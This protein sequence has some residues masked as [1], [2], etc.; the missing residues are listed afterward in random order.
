MAALGDLC[1]V[2]VKGQRHVGEGR[3]FCAQ[4]SIEQDLA[5][6]VAQAVLAA[7]DM[8]DAVAD[9]VHHV[10]EQIERHAVGAD[11]DEILDILVGPFNPA[12]DLIVE[13]DLAHLLR[14]L[15]TDDIR[16]AL[17]LFF[18][19]LFRAEPAA[20]AVVPVIALGCCGGFP[21]GLE[22]FLAAKA[23]VGIAVGQ[24]SFC[25]GHM[26][27]GIFRLKVG[28]LIPIDPEPLQAVKDSF[29]GFLGGAFRVRILDA[30]HQLAPVLAGKQPVVDGGSGPADMEIAGRAGWEADADFGHGVLLAKKMSDAE[31]AAHCG[32]IVF[33][34]CFIYRFTGLFKRMLGKK[35]G[36]AGWGN[37]AVFSSGKSLLY[38]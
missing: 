23:L 16:D 38:L 25:G 20:G 18:P 31:Q 28:A 13:P 33:K 27:F 1:L 15:E 36:K 32:R 35:Q 24:E 34:L 7:D 11:N 4:G 8:G 22:F 6:G 5:R 3:Q 2:Q 37:G 10:A 30:Q 14:H 12:I 29:D 26:L 19:N 17:G 21:F 9:I